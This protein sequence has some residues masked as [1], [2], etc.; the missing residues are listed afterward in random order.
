MIG[1][2]IRKGEALTL[3][4]DDV[5]LPERVFFIRSTLSVVDNNQMPLTT[6]KT[7]GSKAWIALSD[8]VVD[9]LQNRAGTRAF[10]Q[11]TPAGGYVLHRH[12]RPLHPKNVLDL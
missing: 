12:G 11:T 7:K 5:H 10:G 1:T 6:P 9:A 3:H 2:G 4:W 8:R